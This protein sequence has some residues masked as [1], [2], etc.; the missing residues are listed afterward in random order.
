MVKNSKLALEKMDS[1]QKNDFI[2]VMHV[3]EEEQETLFRKGVELLKTGKT[4]SALSLL[5]KAAK[6]SDNLSISSYIAFC[7]A[8]ER[9]QLKYAVSVCEEN[10]K[11]EPANSLHYLN[12]GRIYL[13]MKK[14]ER[15]VLCF[16]E[17]LHYEA[18]AQI[19]D[20]LDSL[21]TRKK[22]V[23]PFLRRSNPLNKY[24]G[25]FL[26]RLKLR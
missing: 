12:L 19:V 26:R 18:N 1:E 9:G 7:I 20:E 11:K 22:P 23:I 6:I 24:L 25:I 13:L 14:K 2:S 16:R 5:E 15:A 8:K 3:P 10:I 21:G 17:G 4:L